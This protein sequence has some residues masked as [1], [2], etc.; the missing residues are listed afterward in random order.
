MILGKTLDQIGYS[1]ELAINGQKAV[2][3]EKLEQFD[4]IFMDLNMPVMDGFQAIEILRKDKGLTLPIIVITANTS[5]HD[6][7]RAFAAGANAHIHKPFNLD[8]LKS[9]LAQYFNQDNDTIK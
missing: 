1:H 7:Q 6:I 8:D 9:V 4:V 2:E 5:Q 3:F